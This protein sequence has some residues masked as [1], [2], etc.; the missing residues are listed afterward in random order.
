MMFSARRHQH[1]CSIWVDRHGD[2]QDG[3]IDFFGTF[4][5]FSDAPDILYPACRGLLR[6]L[7]AE[8]AACCCPL[9][10]LIGTDRHRPLQHLL[11]HLRNRSSRTLA[12]KREGRTQG[13]VGVPTPGLTIPANV[14]AI[15]M[16]QKQVSFTC[17]K[18][19]KLPDDE[20]KLILA[21]NTQGLQQE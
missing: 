12:A 20:T 3:L 21:N 16:A 7:Y 8:G 10:C 15:K 6:F 11:L 18:P 17:I 5:H 19:N 4:N 9:L 14:D 2:G 13:Q 1:T